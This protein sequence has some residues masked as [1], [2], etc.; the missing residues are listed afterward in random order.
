LVDVPLE[1]VS[2]QNWFLK[3]RETILQMATLIL[4]KHIDYTFD[5]DED[6]STLNYNHR[7]FATKAKLFGTKNDKDYKNKISKLFESFKEHYSSENT[8]NL[9]DEFKT[10]VE[11]FTLTL[12]RPNLDKKK[13]ISYPERI[14]ALLR[15]KG[16]AA[17]RE[18]V[19]GF[20]N[21]LQRSVI[22]HKIDWVY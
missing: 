17:Y 2:K 3:K 4:L 13:E 9:R 20:I 7:E 11:S 8:S 12:T 19:K 14:A 15:D 5:D 1:N 6:A 21:L 22:Y 16:Q 10:D 18:D